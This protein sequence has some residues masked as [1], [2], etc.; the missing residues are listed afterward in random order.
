MPEDDAVRLTTAVGAQMSGGIAQKVESI[1]AR[2]E[3]SE[4]CGYVAFRPL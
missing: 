1:H 4:I 2:P 3:P